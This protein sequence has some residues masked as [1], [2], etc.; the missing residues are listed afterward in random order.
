VSGLVQPIGMTLKS[1]CP[2]YTEIT[3][4]EQV[5]LATPL[6]ATRGCLN[7]LVRRASRIVGRYYD[8][9]LKPTGLRATQFNVMAV[10]AHSGAMSL[11]ELAACL[12][13]ERSALARNLKPLERQG[14]AE[15]SAGE[16]KRMRNAELTRLGKEKLRRALPI[17]SRAQSR[18]SKDLGA[19]DA[20][21]LVGLLRGI[22]ERLEGRR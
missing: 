7:F 15:I 1:R 8:A 17:W 14:L 16:D 11:T 2:A 3:M 13:M 20:A 10:L 5:Q 19:S 12:G 9:V 22:T 21:L 4:S 18:L 6:E